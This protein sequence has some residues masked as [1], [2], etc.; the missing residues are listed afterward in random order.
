MNAVALIV[1]ALISGSLVEL[2]E[3]FATADAC[4][5]AAAS[6]IEMTEVLA[7][8]CEWIEVAGATWRITFGERI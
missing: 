3:P 1:T 6:V 5:E 8:E 2:T 4:F 7:V